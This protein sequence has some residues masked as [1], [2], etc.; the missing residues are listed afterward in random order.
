MKRTRRRAWLGIVTVAVL[1]V[2]GMTLAVPAQAAT[3]APNIT[4][5]TTI[6]SA[7]ASLPSSF[8]W[9]SSGALIGPRSDAAHHLVSIKDPSVV[10]FHGRWHMFA[11]TVDTSGNYSMVYLNFTKWS[12]AGS[13]TQHYLDSSAIGT[14]Y[15]TAPMVFFFAPRK[16]WYLV[17]QTGDNASYSTNTD[18]GNPAGW[19]AQQNFYSSMPAIISQN[20]GNGF[21]V[22][23]WVICDSANCYLFSADDNGHLYRSHTT[24]AQFPNGFGGPVIAASDPNRFNFFEAEN[25]YQ[26]SGSNTYLL[27][28]EAFGSDG[29]RN[30]HAFTSPS[31]AGS[32]TPLA[33]TQNNPFAGDADVTFSGTPWTQDISSGEMIRSGVDQTLTI[34]PRHIQYVYQG[35]DPSSNV[36]YNSLPWRL[37]LLT[38]TNS[39]C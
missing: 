32:W 18:I 14:G 6:A 38:Q 7:R 34:N 22:D 9:G 8:R 24:L 23:M 11:S 1:G 39:T 30:F 3:T 21:W 19:S 10:F 17:Y 5:P 20:I 35:H 15:K 26:V 29:R 31:I 25:V 13:A 4:A 33:T 28:M 27:I 16:L 12:Q 36:P 37:G 2:A